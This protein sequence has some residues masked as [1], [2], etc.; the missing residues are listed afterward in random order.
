MFGTVVCP[1]SSY[2]P[3][4]CERDSSCIAESSGEGWWNT[5]PAF[6]L[7]RNHQCLG[8]TALQGK[9]DLSLHLSVV[10][11]SFSSSRLPKTTQ[12]MLEINLPEEEQGRTGGCNGPQ[13][14]AAQRFN[15]LPRLEQLSCGNHF[16]VNLSAAFLSEIN[17][18]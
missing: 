12:L 4:R 13:E 9:K 6:P 18:A 1:K 14:S 2:L 15:H 16:D 10:T 5:F 3:H 17:G 7:W 11:A 8:S